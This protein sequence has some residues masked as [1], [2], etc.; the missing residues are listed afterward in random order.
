MDDRYL[1]LASTGRAILERDLVA[2]LVTCLSDVEAI[3][4]ADIAGVVRRWRLEGKLVNVHGA[5]P[6]LSPARAW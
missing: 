1:E 5:V 2:A 6:D 4:D 3:L